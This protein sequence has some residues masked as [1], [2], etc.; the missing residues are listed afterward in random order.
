MN[1]IPLIVNGALGRLTTFSAPCTASHRQQDQRAFLREVIISMENLDEAT[2]RLPGSG[3]MAFYDLY[4]LSALQWMIGGGKAQQGYA[5]PNI[6]PERRREII[7]GAF[8][9]CVRDLAAR[10]VDDIKLL[11][12]DE[13]ESAVDEYLVAPHAFNAWLQNEAS[14]RL[15]QAFIPREKGEDGEQLWDLAEPSIFWS[16]AGFPGAMQLFAAPFWAADADQYGGP[17]WADIVQ[18]AM[19]LLRSIKEHDPALRM[20]LLVDRLFDIEHNTGSLFSKS[21]STIK[22]GKADLDRRASIRTV[23]EFLPL[24]SPFVRNIIQSSRNYLEA[25][26]PVQESMTPAEFDAMVRV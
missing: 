18:V 10:M 8:D 23:V 15:R 24:V 21:V 20:M 2:Y 17:R 9:A 6:V 13:A 11:A 4:A 7:E 3:R 5:D 1:F 22:V 16:N 26:V 14:P 19:R 12:Y 25:P